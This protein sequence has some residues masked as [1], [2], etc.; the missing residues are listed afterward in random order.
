MTSG[1]DDVTTPDEATP[2]PLLELRDGLPG[3]V[4]D[5]E[6]LDRAVRALAGGTGS[7]RSPAWA[8]GAAAAPPCSGS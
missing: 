6:A 2:A 7:G 1:D 3:V 4:D 8:T 5:P